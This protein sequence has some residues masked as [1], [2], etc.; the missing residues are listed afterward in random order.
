MGSNNSHINYKSTNLST[1]TEVPVL[2][3]KKQFFLMPGVKIRILDSS[4]HLLAKAYG[5]PFKLKEKIEIYSD[6]AMQYKSMTSQTEKILDWNVSFSI[7]SAT[8]GKSIGSLRRKGWS[9]EFVRDS[10]VIFDKT[11]NQIAELLEDSAKNG[12]IRRFVIGFLPQTYHLKTIAGHEL[13]IKQSWNPLFLQYK[14]YSKNYKPLVK[15]VTEALLM[16]LLCTVA[17][18]EGRQ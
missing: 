16:G 17:V 18:I 1:A 7:K 13:I 11:Q 12:L 3:I 8:S 9:S 10:W 2:Y 5:L 15:E 6:E 4:Q 14:C